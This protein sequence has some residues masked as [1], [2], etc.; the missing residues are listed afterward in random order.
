MMKTKDKEKEKR[1]KLKDLRREIE[2]KL[3]EQLPA[4]ILNEETRVEIQKANEEELRDPV[5]AKQIVEALLFAS[6]KPLTVGEIRKVVKAL[7]P[8]DISKIILGLKEDYQ[9]E[10][11]SFEM[12]EIANGFEIATKKEFAP[13]I[14]KIELQKKAKQVT[15]SA[16]ETL[17]IL[18]YKQP[19]TRAEV[20]ELRGVDISGVLSTLVERN[21][22]NIVG[23]KEV[24][25][26]PF[27]YGTTEKFLE[28]FGLSSLK[29]LPDISEIKMLVESSVKKEDLIG[30]THV[31]NVPEGNESA[32][33][34]VMTTETI[35]EETIRNY[36]PESNS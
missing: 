10:Q 12:V 35:K 24:P 22:V 13:W 30:T 20:E 31:V 36:A 26:R 34:E 27:L 21:L 5:K 28:H 7:T 3:E 19:V 23:K 9:R 15:Q 16:L 17:S 25:G 4:E 14:L 18:A 8:T 2:E 33:E 32:P 1:E 29:D 11:R 6:G